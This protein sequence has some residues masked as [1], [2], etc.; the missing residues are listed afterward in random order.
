MKRIKFVGAMV[1]SLAVCSQSYGFDLLDRM[2]GAKKGCGCAAPVSTCC[3]PAPVCCEP[4]PVCC[5][6]APKVCEPAPVCCEAPKCAPACEP[7]C[8]TA[9]EP[10]CDSCDPCAK[11]KKGLFAALTGLFHHHH[12]KHGCGCESACD[13]CAPVCEPVCEPAPVCAPVCEAPACDSCAPACDSCSP[14]GKKKKTLLAG[15]HSLFHHKKKSCGCS[16]CETGCSTC[17]TCES[18]AVMSAPAPAAAPTPAADAPPA[19]AKGADPTARYYQARPFVNA[20]RS[21]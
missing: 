16:T 9:C 20:S 3:E 13:S 2:L 14:C 18:G 4:A 5:P 17:S 21:Y 19:P 10:A 8:E 15:L 7:V 12:K 11:K 6:P 1:L